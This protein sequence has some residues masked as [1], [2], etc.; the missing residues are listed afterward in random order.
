M[1]DSTSRCK[2]CR[3]GRSGRFDLTLWLYDDHANVAESH[4]QLRDLL[5]PEQ[6]RVVLR[7]KNDWC[8]RPEYPDEV[9][10]T[11]TFLAGRHVRNGCRRSDVP[12]T[13]KSSPRREV[14]HMRK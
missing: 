12:R 4:R 9:D 3:R 6:R 11:D 8:R 1:N 13:A 5:S 10:G 7:I 2:S 14:A